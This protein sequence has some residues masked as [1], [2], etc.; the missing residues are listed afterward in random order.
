MKML[1]LNIRGF[2]GDSKLR[3]LHELLLKE[4]IDFISLQ[5]TLMP[6]DV[7]GIVKCLCTLR[8]FSFCSVPAMG[9]SGGQICI[10][11]SDSFQATSSFS[12]NGLLGVIGH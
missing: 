5:E 4:N 1:S 11:K 12:G 10:W 6:G 7:S 3:L 2:G 8:D 9:R